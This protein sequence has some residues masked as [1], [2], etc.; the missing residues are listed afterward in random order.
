MYDILEL[1]SMLVAELR[2][3]A[4]KLNV[5]DYDSMKKQD[6]IYKILDNQALASTKKPKVES[7]E[8]AH[9]APIH[10]EHSHKEVHKKR[11]RIPA[12]SVVKEV[13]DTSVDNLFHQTEET[14]VHVEEHHEQI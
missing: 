14:P 8:I 3:L 5:P 9:H 1:N 10:K 13:K 11:P 2:D 6:L 12:D 4:Q 7:S